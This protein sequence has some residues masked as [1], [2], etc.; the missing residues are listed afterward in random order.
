MTSEEE[1][2]LVA[3]F[4]RGDDTAFNALFAAYKGLVW[5]T[6][7]RTGVSSDDAEPIFHD[8]ILDL[9]AWLKKKETPDSLTAMSRTIARRRAIDFLRKQPLE[10]VPLNESQHLPPSPGARHAEYR[11]LTRQLLVNS[12]ISA[13]Q[14]HA[15]LLHHWEGYTVAEIA[16]MLK[17]PKETIKRRIYLAMKKIRAYVAEQKVT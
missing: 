8:T 11:Q 17:S 2:E 15:L 1:Q 9:V 4:Q 12:G 10:A 13:D 16:A 7:L 14:R 6:I 3:R 5:A